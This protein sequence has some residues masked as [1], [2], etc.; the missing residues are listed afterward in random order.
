MKNGCGPR[1]HPFFTLPILSPP[2]F[3]IPSIRPI[4]PRKN[5]RRSFVSNPPLILVTNDDGIQSPGLHAVAAA[6]ADLG[7][8][9]VM[10]PSRQQTGAGRSYPVLAD[11]T[12]QPT[13]IPL[14]EARYPAYFVRQLSI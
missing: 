6:V 1:P 10:A 5:P 14:G 4:M 7:E 12:L 13:T 11:P 8:L 9:L 3:P 2:H